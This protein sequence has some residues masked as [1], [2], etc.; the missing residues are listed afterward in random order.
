MVF[1]HT[2]R[3]W[4]KKMQRLFFF[5]FIF[6]RRILYRNHYTNIKKM[7]T[8][9]LVNFLS[10]RSLSEAATRGGLW[11]KVFL[12]ISQIRSK[13]PVCARVSFLIKW[14]ASAF[15][16]KKGIWHRCFPVNFAKF[17]RI[18]FLQNTSRWL[19]L[20]SEISP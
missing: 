18:P 19:L 7:K 13:T 6:T 2:Q 1:N 3:I 16:L 11:K 8:A 14:Q 10:L 9:S 12:E 20:L 15:L 4:C 5:F 17:L